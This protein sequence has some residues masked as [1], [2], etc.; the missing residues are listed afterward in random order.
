MFCTLDGRSSSVGVSQIGQDLVLVFSGKTLYALALPFLHLHVGVQM[1]VLGE[2]NA[3]GK[4]EQKDV[5]SIDD[6]ETGISCQWY[7]HVV[8]ITWPDKTVPYVHHSATQ[9]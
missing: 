8:W 3:G 2:F 9:G 4:V 5:L 6:T 1:G 7:K